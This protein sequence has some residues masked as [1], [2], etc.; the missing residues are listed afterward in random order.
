MVKKILGFIFSFII[1]FSF[2]SSTFASQGKAG[3][4]VSQRV[5]ELLQLRTSGGIGEEVRV[6]AREQNEVQTR[7]AEKL[8]KLQ[9]RKAWVKKMIG[10]DRK[11][12][13]S[14]RDE[15]HQNEV[16]IQKL[17]TLLTKLTN[18]AD[19]TKVQNMITALKEENTAL[20][21]TITA[22]ENTRSMFG[23]LTKLLEK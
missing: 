3:G 16:R 20:M 1:L 13:K 21:A 12:L 19:K 6:I 10:T 15:I 9:S 5:Q 7:L 2:V 4:G 22:E 14:V 11:V 18:Q 17:E 23:W 8:E